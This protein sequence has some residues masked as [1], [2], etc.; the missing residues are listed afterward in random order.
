MRVHSDKLL[1]GMVVQMGHQDW[2]TVTGMEFQMNGRVVYFLDDNPRPYV[3]D[4]YVNVRD[5]P[6]P[7]TAATHV[8]M[9]RAW[10]GR[11]ETSP[12]HILRI[13]ETTSAPMAEG[14]CGVETVATSRSVVARLD[15]PP[16]KACARCAVRAVRT[17]AAFIAQGV[18]HV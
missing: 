17:G 15:S 4:G 1:R 6:V 3:M 13:G 16:G 9:A 2:R 14:L 18:S 7:E 10:R 12:W 11:H 5:Q 8:L